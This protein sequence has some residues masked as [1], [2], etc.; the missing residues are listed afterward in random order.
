MLSRKR[1]GAAYLSAYECVGYRDGMKILTYSSDRGPRL[2]AV[3]SAGIVDLNDA[4]PQ[5]PACAKAF[6]AGGAELRSRAEK[7]IQKRRLR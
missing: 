2:A 1:R 5:L 4:D 7:A 6:L 3:T